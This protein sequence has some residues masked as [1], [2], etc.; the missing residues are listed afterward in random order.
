MSPKVRKHALC[1]VVKVMHVYVAQWFILTVQRVDIKLVPLIACR[2]VTVTV[3][4]TWDQSICIQ[5]YVGMYK[6]DSEKWILCLSP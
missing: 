3:T 6:A 5:L 1:S 2:R 4:L